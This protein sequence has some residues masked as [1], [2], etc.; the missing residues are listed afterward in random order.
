MR[1]VIRINEKT[2]IKLIS[3]VINEQ[4]ES[5]ENMKKIVDFLKSKGYN[6]TESDD[7]QI[8]LNKNLLPKK[9][10]AITIFVNQDRLLVYYIDQTKKKTKVIEKNL[11]S[12]IDLNK[13]E[14]ELKSIE[15]KYGRM[16]K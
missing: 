16:T 2:L 14:E 1:K 7:F 12:S 6:Q 11:Q 8:V 3:Q 15:I 5:G 13:L 9:E 4:Q 10:V